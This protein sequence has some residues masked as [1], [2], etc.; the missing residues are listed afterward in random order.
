VAAVN[1]WSLDPNRP[2]TRAQSIGQYNGVM[3][4]ARHD[5]DV[6][7]IA[8]QRH[9]DRFETLTVAPGSLTRSTIETWLSTQHQAANHAYNALRGAT[10]IADAPPSRIDRAPGYE[11]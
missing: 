4:S 2:A 10:N 6:V 9:H 8:P 5:G 1:A 11:R 7:H 3:L